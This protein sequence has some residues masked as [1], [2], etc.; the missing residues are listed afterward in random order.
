MVRS[1]VLRGLAGLLSVAFV[2]TFALFHSQAVEPAAHDH[3]TIESFTQH[4]TLVE[5]PRDTLPPW[6]EILDKNGA[7]IPQGLADQEHPPSP[8]AP[9]DSLAGTGGAVEAAGVDAHPAPTLSLI[10]SGEAPLDSAVGT[11]AAEPGSASASSSAE[12]H[13]LTATLKELILKLDRPP[14]VA[15]E[16]LA[17][18]AS[19]TEPSATLLAPVGPLAPA[20]PLAAMAPADPRAPSDPR[21]LAD[22]LAP[23]PSSAAPSASPSDPWALWSAASEA[24]LAELYDGESWRFDA[25]SET[26]IELGDEYR[27]ARVQAQVQADAALVAAEA[28]EDGGGDDESASSALV[29]LVT[30]ALVE[31]I[32]NDTWAGGAATLESG[33]GTS[34][35]W[36]SLK[37]VLPKE[38]N[39]TMIE[40]GCFDTTH[41]AAAMVAQRFPDASVLALH[42]CA[43]PAAPRPAP[44]P[45]GEAGLGALVRVRDELD[46]LNLHVARRPEGLDRRAVAALKATLAADDARCDYLGLS[47]LAGLSRGLMPFELEA[48]LAD[49]LT[50]C[51]VAVLPPGL[52][53]TRFFSY[54][55][56]VGDLVRRAADRLPW[57]HAVAIAE[58]APIPTPATPAA[59]PALSSRSHHY[60]PSYGTRTTRQMALWTARVSKKL[61]PT[62]PL[63]APARAAPSVSPVPAAPPPRQSVFGAG[64]AAPTPPAPPVEPS[65][66]NATSAVRG[67]PVLSPRLLLAAGVVPAHR[68]GLLHRVALEPAPAQ[69]NASD[70]VFFGRGLARAGLVA[71]RVAAIAKEEAEAAL[72]R[73]ALDREMAEA[74]AR[75]ASTTTSATAT[76]SSSAF[77]SSPASAASPRYSSPYTRSSRR[78]LGVLFEGQPGAQGPLP[79]GAEQQ[80]RQS[81]GAG[82]SASGGGTG[83]VGGA[84]V[85]GFVGD[86]AE[87]A[88]GAL[89]AAEEGAFEAAWPGLRLELESENVGS[90]VT[91]G[92]E[93]GLLGIKVAQA[94]SGSA[95]V[96]GAGTGLAHSSARLSL[97]D[98]LVV[99]NYLPCVSPLDHATVAALLAPGGHPF[100]L[101]VLGPS[102][103]ATALQHALAPLGGPAPASAADCDW[104]SVERLLGSMLRLAPTSFTLLPRLAGLAAGLDVLLPVCASSFRARYGVFPGGGSGSGLSGAFDD[105]A[106]VSGQAPVPGTSGGDPVSGSPEAVLLA[107]AL[108]AG[109]RGEGQAR[110]RRVRVPETTAGAEAGASAGHAPLVLFRVHWEPVAVDDAGA[111]A[112]APVGGVSLYSLLH[113]GLVPAVKAELL[114]AYLELPLW[115]FAALPAL[116]PWKVRFDAAAGGRLSLL[117]PSPGAAGAATGGAYAGSGGAEVLA[118]GA[119]KGGDGSSDAVNE[120]GKATWAT[121]RG[122]LERSPAEHQNGHFSLVEYGSGGG[123]LSML[124]AA[125]FP[126]ATVLSLADDRAQA[127]Q[128][129]ASVQERKLFNNLVADGAAPYAAGSDPDWKSVATKFSESPEFLRCEGGHAASAAPSLSLACVL[130]VTPGA[131]ANASAA[132]ECLTPSAPVAAVAFDAPLW[133]LTPQKVHGARPLAT[134]QPQRLPRGAAVVEPHLLPAPPHGQAPLGRARHLFPTR[135]RPPCGARRGLGAGLARP[136][137]TRLRPGQGRRRRPLRAREPPLATLR[138]PRRG[139]SPRPRRRRRRGHHRKRAAGGGAPRRCGAPAAAL[140]RDQHDPPRASPFRI[141]AGWPHAHLHHDG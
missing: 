51:T 57:N 27:Q 123:A 42:A 15:S 18:V 134:G 104:R 73:A 3:P 31:G 137:G 127:A 82:G 65:A 71:A 87:A 79:H 36:A 116:A 2:G 77:S 91:L 60:T 47:D 40:V 80:A 64:A 72:A 24:R 20:D 76:S 94:F 10:A 122:E 93:L 103:V 139:P 99:R 23:L 117:T 54:W 48:L 132:H 81:G 6:D 58:A 118:S 98:L 133:P 55:A 85:G 53:D 126:N 136:A 22:P 83:A 106:A 112:L 62:L 56:G 12:L 61:P 46:L 7:L 49:A 29:A 11:V 39:F 28:G 90:V 105:A 26:P 114:R 9:T 75:N 107:R 17:V 1:Q 52:P 41:L 74:A 4:R 8:P 141:C 135:P 97:L 115:R 92:S 131:R 34:Q 16:S 30:R 21:T 128:H 86:E 129:L 69:P 100:E 124:V 67:S 111:A 140:R 110:V 113:L 101:A 84:R 25:S 96:V 43:A 102:V 89:L 68:F 109:G 19:R 95:T 88:Q 125:R 138:R 63:P 44:H 78:L 108:G 70:V 121:L 59:A 13:Y 120:R 50:L 45:A 5:A 66:P 38:G 130:A 32:G 35:W 37:G 14:A 119:V 33:A